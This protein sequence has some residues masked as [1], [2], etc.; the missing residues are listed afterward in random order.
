LSQCRDLDSTQLDSSL[1]NKKAV[2]PQGNHTM[3]QLFFLVSVQK[4]HSLQV[5]TTSQALKA[6]RQ[7]SKHTGAK[8]NIKSGFKVTQSHA[9]G[10]SGKTVRQ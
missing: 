2:L 9:F 5:A 10:V 4:Q 3:P 1:F 7:S 6:R 8:Q